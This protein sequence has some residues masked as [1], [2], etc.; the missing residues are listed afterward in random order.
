MSCILFFGDIVGE[1]GRVSLMKALPQ[2]KAEFNADIIIVNAENAAGGK[3]LTPKIAQDLLGAGV[4]LITLGDH[5]W[6]QSNLAPW[7]SADQPVVR[8]LNLQAG[9]PGQGS[10]IYDCPQGRLGLI[11]LMGRTFMRP[12]AENPFPC[13]LKEAQRLREEENCQIIFVDMHAETT[14]EKIAMGYHL[15]GLATVIAGTH[16]HVQTADARILEKGS[17][18]ISD[19]GMC[20]SLN[21]V[22]GREAQPVLQGFITSMPNKLPVG[23]W[24]VQLN[25]VAVEIDW[26]QGKAISIQAFIRYYNKDE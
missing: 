5:V 19:V 10:Y 12:M 7:L 15:D 21:G 20:G 11:N 2:L 16:T 23:G 26:A 4:N 9:T 18:Y 8:P 17:A 6:D 14:S 22:I 24:P 1:C 13:A 3:G 25:G